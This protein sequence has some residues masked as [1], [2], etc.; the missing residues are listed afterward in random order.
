[1]GMDDRDSPYSQEMK[2]R[3][4]KAKLKLRGAQIVADGK[5]GMHLFQSLFAQMSFVRHEEARSSLEP[6][7]IS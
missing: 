6:F 1:M 4:Q 5:M 2:S 7:D 3:M